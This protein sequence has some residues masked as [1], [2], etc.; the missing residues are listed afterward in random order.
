MSVKPEVT[1]TW[2]W[3]KTK[4]RA[5]SGS[6]EGA[7][8]VVMLHSPPLYEHLLVFYIV[9]VVWVLVSLG[10]YETLQCRIHDV[11]GIDPSSSVTYLSQST[12]SRPQWRLESRRVIPDRQEESSAGGGLMSMLSWLG[13]TVHLFEQGDV[14]CRRDAIGGGKLELVGDRVELLG[15]SERTYETRT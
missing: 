7:T 8:Q 3:V 6:F 14:K 9:V 10:V 15:N 11:V 12:S 1:L 2:K 5:P 4:E 13:G